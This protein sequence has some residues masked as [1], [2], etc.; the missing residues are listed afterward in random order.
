MEVKALAALLFIFYFSPEC[1][2]QSTEKIRKLT[3]KAWKSS[4]DLVAERT[5]PMSLPTSEVC[6]C[7]RLS[8]MGQPRLPES[9]AP[10]SLCSP[11]LLLRTLPSAMELGS[12]PPAPWMPPTHMCTQ[13]DIHRVP[14]QGRN[15]MV[16]RKINLKAITE[17]TKSGGKTNTIH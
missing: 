1:F 16:R 17:L 11:H 4:T 9:V 8:R 10:S 6:G 7:P 3:L 13:Q 14:H 2:Y 12:C 5:R 15:V